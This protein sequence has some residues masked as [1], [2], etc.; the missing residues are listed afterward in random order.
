MGKIRGKTERTLKLGYLQS[1]FQVSSSQLCFP[2]KIIEFELRTYLFRTA[3]WR[4]QRYVRCLQ[5][6]SL[7]DTSPFHVAPRL[8]LHTTLRLWHKVRLNWKRF[9]LVERGFVSWPGLVL[10]FSR[11]YSMTVQ[12][13]LDNK[14]NLLRGRTSNG[15]Y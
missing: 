13:R 7:T 14:I 4:I 11:G 12:I 6:C 1:V 5:R 8:L 15:E 10:D 2:I 9:R 3:L